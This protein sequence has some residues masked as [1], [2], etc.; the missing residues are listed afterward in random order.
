[1]PIVAIV[2]VDGSLLPVWSSP[3]DQRTSLSPAGRVHPIKFVV[4][5]NDDSLT[6]EDAALGYKGAWIIEHCFKKLKTTGLEIR[7]IYHWT[8]HRIVAHV[9]LCTLALQIQ[10]AAEIRT[11]ASWARIAHELAALKAV[12]YRTE[13]RTIV[14]RTRIPSELGDVLKQLAVSIPKQLLAVSEPVSESAAA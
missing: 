5:T 4:T 12:R 2:M 9:K 14:Q 1:M 10:R 6:A 3:A 13:A 7:P 8:Q 11:G